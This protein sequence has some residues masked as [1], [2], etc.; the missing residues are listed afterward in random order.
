[1]IYNTGKMRFGLEL[2]Y[3]AAAFGTPDARGRVENTTV[4]GNFRTL[5]GVFYFF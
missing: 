2:E 1:L 5:L 3:T 4:V